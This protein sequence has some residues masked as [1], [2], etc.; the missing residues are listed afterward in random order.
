MDSQLEFSKE[1]KLYEIVILN[2][3]KHLDIVLVIFL[4]ISG[5]NRIDVFHITLL[6]Y[7]TLFIVYP[8]FMRKNFTYFIY[9][10]VLVAILRYV[11]VLFILEIKDVYNLFKALTVL[12][13]SNEFNDEGKFWRAAML[14]DSW[15]IVLLAYL[16]YQLYNSKLLENH[17][18]EDQKTEEWIIFNVRYPKA[19]KAYIFLSKIMGMFLPWL[20]YIT[21]IT[22]VIIFDK[23]IISLQYIGST[24]LILL[25]H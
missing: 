6:I 14:S 13:L 4:Y 5:T 18:K 22:M 2:M 16:Q 11:Y 15:V 10:V 3:L 21:L 1:K 23:T 25:V 7:F 12:G 20:I 19:S 8:Y 9:F 17:Y 24:L